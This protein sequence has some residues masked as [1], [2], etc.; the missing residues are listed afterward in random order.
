MKSPFS[1]NRDDLLL[2]FMETTIEKVNTAL[3]GLYALEKL[4]IE[5][6]IVSEP[7]LKQRL[8]D[9]KTLPNRLVGVSTL[10]EMV[11][12]YRAEDKRIAD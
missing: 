11:E 5:K 10:R 3:S 9:A 7:E 8:K 6:N 4:L 2:R 1:D 12:N